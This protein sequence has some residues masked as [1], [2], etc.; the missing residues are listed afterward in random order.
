MKTI[1]YLMLGVT[2]ASLCAP[3]MVSA[4]TATPPTTPPVVVPHDDRDLHRDLAGAPD[5]IKTL[6][7]SFDQTRDKFL[8]QQAVLLAKLKNAHCRP[9]IEIK[10]AKQ[11]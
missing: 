10:A 2:F 3:R 4:Q 11:G 7:V 6:I 5:A 1:R 9:V 8:A